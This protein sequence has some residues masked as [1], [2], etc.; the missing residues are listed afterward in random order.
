MQERLIR[1]LKE[2]ILRALVKRD[3]TTNI[4]DGLVSLMQS[5]WDTAPTNMQEMRASKNTKVKGDL[6]EHFCVLYFQHCYKPRPTN[7]W[8]LRDIPDNI[9]EH[10]SMSKAD[11]GIDIILEYKGENDDDD[12]G[13]I[14]PSENRYAAVQVK[15]R[16][17][18]R[19]KRYSGVGWKQLATFYGLVNKTGPYIK[20]IVITNASYVR[21]IG[22]K[23][24]LD[25]SICLKRLQAIPISKW[26]Q[27]SFIDGGRSVSGKTEE[28]L[29]TEEEEVVVVSKKKKVKP[30]RL[31]PSTENPSDLDDLRQRRLAFYQNM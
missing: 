1:I 9:L 8:L 15:F 7:V 21:H 17:Q 13:N 24:D 3:D 28:V 16:K 27:M 25:Y 14:D 4:F 2:H 10:L 31:D 29:L 20:H 12:L 18:N 11:L 23:T 19:Y 26:H 30:K 22:K 6:F 5:D